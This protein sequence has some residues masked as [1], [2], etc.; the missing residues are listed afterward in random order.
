MRLSPAVPLPT[1]PVVWEQQCLPLMMGMM[2]SC[3]RVFSGACSEN[4]CRKG[5]GVSVP[6]EWQGGLEVGILN[7]Q[8]LPSPPHTVAACEGSQA[9]IILS[10]LA[11]PAPTAWNR[12]ETWTEGS[13]CE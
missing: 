10:P 1:H 6:A 9:I 4:S 13:S 3:S 11:T 7:G 12:C 8:P 2:V 5:A